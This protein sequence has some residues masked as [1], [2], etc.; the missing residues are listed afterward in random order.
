MHF[1][2]N[3]VKLINRKYSLII[4]KFK[5]RDLEHIQVLFPMMLQFI[6]WKLIL[7][8]SL[9]SSSAAKTHY[10]VILALATLGSSFNSICCD[11]LLILFHCDSK[12][13]VLSKIRLALLRSQSYSR[14]PI[15]TRMSRNA[16]CSEFGYLI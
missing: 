16:P 8:T 12:S 14:H 4:I 6:K 13:L 10:S 2:Q 1:E 7:L 11:A 5:R 3:T 15:K 9:L